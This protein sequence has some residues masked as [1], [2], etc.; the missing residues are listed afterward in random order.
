MPNNAEGSFRGLQ[1]RGFEKETGHVGF[2][3]VQGNGQ[4]Q[5]VARPIEDRRLLYVRLQSS[6]RAQGDGGQIVDEKATRSLR[7]IGWQVEELAI[8]RRRGLRLPVWST[9]SPANQI[10]QIVEARRSGATV[11]VS[12][13]ALFGEPH[14]LEDAIALVHNYFPA[15]SFSSHRWL[16][17]YFKVGSEA[18]FRRAFASAKRV[19]F[20]SERDRQYALREQRPAAEADWRFLPPPPYEGAL[21]SREMDVIHVS[22]TYNWLPKKLSRLSSREAALVSGAGFTLVD[23]DSHFKPCF[24][25]LVDRFSVGFKLKL[26][27]MMFC[28]DVIASLCDVRQEID[29]IAPEYPFFKQVKSVA[30]AIA[31]F[32]SVKRG[33]SAA[34]IDRRFEESSLQARLPGWHDFAEGLVSDHGKERHSVG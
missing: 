6:A 11:V 20:L 9:G 10:E 14:I 31:Y 7:E 16:E 2:S 24:G 26:M 34:E 18:F 1:I 27:Q 25:L 3:L 15:F 8:E 17:P 12:H 19:V 33:L 4:V 32:D 23:F 22:G 13:E 30:E 21:G 28:R 5:N 29:G